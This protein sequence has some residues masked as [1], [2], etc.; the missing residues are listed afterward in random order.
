MRTEAILLSI[1]LFVIGAGLGYFISIG[2]VKNLTDER[3]KRAEEVL[4]KAEDKANTIRRNAKNEAK[5]IE[6]ER[7]GQEDQTVPS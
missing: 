3:E 1:L 7:R 4:K 5:Q 6:Q 2:K